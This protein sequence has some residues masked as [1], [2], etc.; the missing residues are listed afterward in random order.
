MNYTI[1]QHNN[2]LK[3]SA[4]VPMQIEDCCYDE[5]SDTFVI[6]VKYY[7]GRDY[8]IDYIVLNREWKIVKKLTE[9]KGVNPRFVLAPDKS[10]WIGMSATQTKKDGEIVLPLYGRERITKEVVKSDLGTDYRFF[11]NGSFWGYVCDMW[12]EKKP[13][14]LLQYEFD[15]KGL[16]KNRKA[17]KLEGLRNA[18][19]FVQGDELYLCQQ[20][21]ADGTVSVYR[22]MEPGMT[23]L[24]MEPVSIG[25]FT[26]CYLVKVGE[27][28]C[29]F[30]GFRENE[31]HRLSIDK[32]GQVLEQKHI[33]TMDDTAFYSIMDLQVLADG[34]VVV[35]YVCEN[36]C[37]TIEIEQDNVRDVFKKKNDTLYCRGKE[38][39]LI[40]K[41]AF[42][43]MTDGKNCYHLATNIEASG[44]KCKCIYVCK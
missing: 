2:C 19:P 30:V 17:W 29:E 25:G 20:N 27:D 33:Y 36:Q 37:G 11:R 22:M 35:S 32:S 1:K 26:W 18:V 24:V 21:W 8:Y 28:A 38:I 5:T 14:K 44:G 16:F 13:D 42:H 10:V 43:I 6:A 31:I 15:Q 41:L 4:E 12:S 34:R 7:R 39:A 23:E 3:I 9:T 40:E